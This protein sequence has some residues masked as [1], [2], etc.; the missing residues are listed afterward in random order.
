MMKHTA[1][2]YCF[3]HIGFSL[4]EFCNISTFSAAL[5]VGRATLSR[6]AC[7]S[8]EL[9]PHASLLLRRANVSNPPPRSFDLR[10]FHSA[11]KR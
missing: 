1:T 10:I 6:R 5:R 8:P 2:E 7:E 3:R 11:W 4:S 9:H